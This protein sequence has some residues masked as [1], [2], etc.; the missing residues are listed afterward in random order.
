VLKRRSRC[1][2]E[3]E[4]LKD[5][6]NIERENDRVAHLSNGERLETTSKKREKLFL[7][8]SLNPGVSGGTG[9]EYS[10]GGRKQFPIEGIR[11]GGRSY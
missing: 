8:K 11:G 9:R 3:L 6:N 5:G 4:F 10:S 2:S 7:S 1:Q